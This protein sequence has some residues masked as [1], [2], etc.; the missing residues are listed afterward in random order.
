[1]DIDLLSGR[2]HSVIEYSAFIASP[3]I[4]SIIARI[5][6]LKWIR[7]WASVVAPIDQTNEKRNIP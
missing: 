3:N 2:S 5:S 1:M 7:V 6:L 4:P